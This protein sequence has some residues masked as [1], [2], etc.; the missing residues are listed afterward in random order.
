MYYAQMAGFNTIGKTFLIQLC[1]ILL[2]HC[3]SY[4]TVCDIIQNLVLHGVRSLLSKDPQFISYI[5]NYARDLVKAKIKDLSS[6]N[7]FKMSVKDIN[8]Q[9]LKA[10]L[11]VTI[12]RAYKQEAHF[13]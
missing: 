9:Q 6:S 1:S 7:Q 5:A 2:K 4:T 13:L 8:P 12:D 10:F 11:L 3:E